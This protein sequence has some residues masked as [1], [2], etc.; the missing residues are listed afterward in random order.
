MKL[1][2]QT[3]SEPPFPY[4]RMWPRDIFY[5]R[6]KAKRED[7]VFKRP[8]S[9]LFRTIPVLTKPGVYVLYRDDVPYYVGKAKRLRTRLWSHACV[10]GARY[11][12]HWNFFSFFVI[13]GDDERARRKR[14]DIESVLIAAMPTANGAKPLK[15]EPFPKEVREMVHEIRSGRA[16]P[17]VKED[18]MRTVAAENEVKP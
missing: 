5:R 17:L 1:E 9:L 14:N 18:V 6:L 3:E 15:R 7:L 2:K 4:G 8:T 13:E 12:N 10:P 11:S 16:N